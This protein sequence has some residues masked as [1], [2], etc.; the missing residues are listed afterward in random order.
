M[1]ALASC[2]VLTLG[3]IACVAALR[4]RDRAV[5]LTIQPTLVY[6]PPPHAPDLAELRQLLEPYSGRTL[7]HGCGYGNT[8]GEYI[9]FLVARGETGDGVPMHQQHEL[10]GGCREVADD[11]R[12][13]L[14]SIVADAGAGSDYTREIGVPIRRSDRAVDFSQLGCL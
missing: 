6:A 2:L 12:Y 11:P 7:L 8:L 1:R 9:A 13:W 14:C 10:L 4:G 5:V 3:I